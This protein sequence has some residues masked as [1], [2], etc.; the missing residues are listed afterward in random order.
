MAGLDVTI[1]KLKL[2]DGNSI[3]MLGYGT[4]TAWSKKGEESKHDQAVIDGVKTAIK[5]GY[6][7]LDGAESTCHHRTHRLRKGRNRANLTLSV[8]N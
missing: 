7:H 5:L 3:P 6:M 1:P 4:G 2:N 8:Q